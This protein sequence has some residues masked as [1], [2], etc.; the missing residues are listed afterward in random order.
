V[1]LTDAELR[2]LTGYATP[3]KQREAL[4]RMGYRF[5]V[6]PDGRPRL[7]RSAV[8][9]RQLGGKPEKRPRFEALEA[10]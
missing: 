7:L 1:F 5:D 3:R 8:E 9:A 10:T 4:A 6:R 2:D